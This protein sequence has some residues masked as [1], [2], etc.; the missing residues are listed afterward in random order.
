MAEDSGTMRTI[1]R[2]ALKSAGVTD[3]VEAENGA[4][5]IDFFEEGKFDLVMADWN[6][7]QKSGLDVARHIRSLDAKVPI[8]MVTTE[9]ERHRVVEAVQAGVSDYLIKPFTTEALQ[10]KLN[11]F[12]VRT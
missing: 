1:L 5:A 6:M 2:R 4:E 3:V 10:Q 12:A 8:L 9:A 7:P 11:R